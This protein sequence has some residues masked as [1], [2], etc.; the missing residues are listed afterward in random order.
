MQF[1]PVTYSYILTHDAF[2]RGIVNLIYRGHRRRDEFPLAH[3]HFSVQIAETDQLLTGP[4]FAV[5]IRPRIAARFL[6]A[7]DQGIPA[8]SSIIT[9]AT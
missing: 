6:A 2:K 9:N 3:I 8:A 1:F 7:D 4:L 5:F